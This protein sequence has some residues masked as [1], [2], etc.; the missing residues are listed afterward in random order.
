MYLRGEMVGDGR[1]RSRRIVVSL[2]EIVI[3]CVAN[4]W[5]YEIRD[6]KPGIHIRTP[7]SLNQGY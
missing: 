5:E 1:R 3:G 7:K 6:G 4:D 2:I